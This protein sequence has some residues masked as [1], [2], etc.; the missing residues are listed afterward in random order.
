MMRAS[1]SF[2]GSALCLAPTSAAQGQGAQPRQQKPSAGGKRDDRWIGRHLQRDVIK[3][4]SLAHIAPAFSTQLERRYI[5]QNVVKLGLRY[6]KAR[7][8]KC[9]R[10]RI[11]SCNWIYGDCVITG[12]DAVS[13]DPYLSEPAGLRRERDLRIIRA[14]RSAIHDAQYGAGNGGKA[15]CE[16]V[17]EVL[18]DACS[19]SRGPDACCNDTGKN[20]SPFHRNNPSLNILEC[21]QT[22]VE[23]VNGPIRNIKRLRRFAQNAK[24]Q[25]RAPSHLSQDAA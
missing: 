21:E 11:P 16:A 19:M 20:E 7:C 14:A 9:T 10:G 3:S 13:G 22:A 8:G 18:A 4:N 25:E 15:V 1:R 17:I 12:S 2:A 24:Q 23:L 6:A 5:G